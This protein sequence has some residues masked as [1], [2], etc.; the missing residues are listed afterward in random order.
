MSVSRGR[1]V[2]RRPRRGRA[3]SRRQPTRA[4]HVRQR[5]WDEPLPGSPR[6]GPTN[7]PARWRQSAVPAPPVGGVWLEP[8]PRRAAIRLHGRHRRGRQRSAKFFGC[9]LVHSVL[10]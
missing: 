3:W 4:S 1:A 8:R 5:D 6:T 9:V 10:V 2:S 7:R